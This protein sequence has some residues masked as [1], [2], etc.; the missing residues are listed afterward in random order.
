MLQAS[1]VAISTEHRDALGQYPVVALYFNLEKTEKEMKK[2]DKMLIYT[3][4][5]IS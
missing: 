5:L 2:H 3:C 4:Y 1:R